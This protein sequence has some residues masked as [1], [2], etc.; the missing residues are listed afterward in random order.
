VEWLG[1]ERLEEEKLEEN[2]NKR[3]ESHPFSLA[4]GKGE[5][6]TIFTQSQPSPSSTRLLALHDPKSPHAD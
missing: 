5:G 2:L 3:L 6:F 1:L 4:I